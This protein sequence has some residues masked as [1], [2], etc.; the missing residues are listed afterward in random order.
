MAA[1]T[2]LRLGA[3]ALAVAI[4]ATLVLAALPFLQLG[5]GTN[6]PQLAL[7]V[8]RLH[9]TVLHLPVALLI[10]AL[11]LEATRLPWLARLAPDFPPSV[12]ASVLWLASL[13]GLGAA[14]AGWC[15][16][17][18]G[19]YDADLLGRH[20]WAGVA[21]ATGAF[22]CLVLHTLAIAR[23]DRTAL[24]HLL[25]LVVLVTGGVMVVAAHAGGS[26]THGEDY[27]TEHAPTPIRR[28]AGLPIPRDR[29]LERRTAIADR[30]VF[31][32][33]AL[34][35]L[36]RHC[37]ACHNPGKRKGDLAMDTHAGVMAGGVSGPVV[38]AGVAA[39]SEL[40]RRLHLP[41][42][43]KKHMP[44]KGRPSLTDDEMAV[45]T[46]W[47]AA[48]APAAGTLRTA[49]A[50]AEVRAAFSRI[51]PESERQE[52]E[53]H[54]RRQAA[55]YE[56]TLASLR[57]SV[58]GSLRAIVPGERELEYTAAV[59]G[60]AF[61]DA[62]LAK[63]SAVG[64]DL[65]WLDLSRTAVTDAGLKA[66]TTMP[67]LEHLDLRETA[68]G[69]AGVAALA[70]LANLRT[71]GLYG[72][73]VSDEGVP[74]IQRLAG[75]TRVYVGGTRVTERGIAALRTARKDLRIAP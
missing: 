1:T 75:V 9:P 61:G 63:L 4:P 6:L 46:W 44:P 20:L 11:L 26:L 72:T 37:T 51:L 69:D 52:I 31:D 13:T 19:G 64:R 40:L 49:K 33:V 35:V 54:Q 70:P 53:A 34:R 58:P 38:I 5:D 39:E 36:E 3:T 59:A 22:V 41:L 17:H 10:L 60:K 56:A 48:G 18:E 8:G 57:A 42:D 24:R 12:L 27:L 62:E 67:N 47:V 65:V 21:T 73:A 16:S 50:P 7:F 45:L 55:E 71:L 29:S 74:S 25:T 66:L 14:V 2:M 68:I 23:P 15:L 30:E 32:G 28:L 43:D